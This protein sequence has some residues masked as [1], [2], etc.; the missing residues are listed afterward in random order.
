LHRTGFSD[1]VPSS[2]DEFETFVKQQLASWGTKINDTHVIQPE[3]CRRH[4]NSLPSPSVAEY[5]VK[6][7]I[8]IETGKSDRYF[9]YA[10]TGVVAATPFGVKM[11][12]GNAGGGRDT[13][14]VI[15]MKL[16]DGV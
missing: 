14:P 9:S 10:S 6:K 1:P 7:F 2:P 11:H 16:E 15:D 12:S 3:Q 13:Q 5:C 4:L 8:A